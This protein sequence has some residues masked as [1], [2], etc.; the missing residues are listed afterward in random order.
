VKSEATTIAA[1]FNRPEPK[2]HEAVCE[3]YERALKTI[4]EADT[5]SPR[6][7]LQEV[8]RESLGKGQQMRADLGSPFAQGG[9]ILGFPDGVNWTDDK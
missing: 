4:A 5:L 7:L 1:T 3:H 2:G 6:G 8:A 9:L